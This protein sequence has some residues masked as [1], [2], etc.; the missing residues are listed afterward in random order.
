MCG[1]RDGVAVV[2]VVTVEGVAV[3][4]Y[5]FSRVTLSFLKSYMH[6]R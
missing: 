1:L 2:V 5:S 3:E 4:S 6:H